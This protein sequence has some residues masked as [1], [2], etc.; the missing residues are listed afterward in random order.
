MLT[1]GQLGLAVQPPHLRAL[2]WSSD[3]RSASRNRC[4]KSR[5]CARG[6]GEGAAC[7]G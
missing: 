2:G 1:P 5:V 6:E 7:V 3:L 4:L